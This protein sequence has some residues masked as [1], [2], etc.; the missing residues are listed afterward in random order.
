MIFTTTFPSSFAF[1]STGA[2]PFTGSTYTH[3]SRFDDRMVV[4][5]IDVSAWQDSIDWEAAKKSGVDYAIIRIGYRG[6]GAEGK[7]QPDN[8]FVRNIEAAKAGKLC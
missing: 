5:G 1:A 4:H 8:W 3:N 7:M 6:H 2:S